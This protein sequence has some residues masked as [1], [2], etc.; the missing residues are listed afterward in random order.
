MTLEDMSCIQGVLCGAIFCLSQPAEQE[1]LPASTLFS[2]KVGNGVY[3][4]PQMQIPFNEL[5]D[6]EGYTYLMVV[7]TKAS[8][9]YY[10]QEKDPHVHDFK[11]WGYNFGDRLSDRLNPLVYQ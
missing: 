8:A 5:I 7:Y 6:R 10:F 2:T 4:S 1:E 9:V 3:F 11:H